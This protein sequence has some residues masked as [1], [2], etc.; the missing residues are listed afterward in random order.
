MLSADC[1]RLPGLEAM[2]YGKEIIQVP[3][4]TMHT[5]P[6]GLTHLTATGIPRVRLA[7]LFPGSGVSFP[8][9]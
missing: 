7:Q 2:P 9:P 5:A 1:S 4:D 8:D 6:C 3:P